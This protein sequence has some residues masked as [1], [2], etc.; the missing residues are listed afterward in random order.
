VDLRAKLARLKPI[1][2]REQPAPPEVEEPSG[3][4]VPPH[5]EAL[6]IRLAEVLEKSREKEARRAAVRAAAIEERLRRA[7]L[8]F[9]THETDLGPLHVRAVRHAGSH[10]VGRVPL[11]AGIE[12]DAEAIAL[13]ALDPTIGAVDPARALYLD[14]EATGLAGGTGTIPFLIGLA[15]FEE[16]EL[17]VE[18]LL[19]RRLGDEAPILARVAERIA[20]ASMLVSFNGK[21]FDL[22]L[23]RT[24]FVMNR[25]PRPA[26][27]PHL[28]LVHL[29][30]RVHRGV[31]GRGGDGD[32]RSGPTIERW[33]GESE[34][35][36]LRRRTSCKLVALE[37]QVLG[38]VRVDD[39]PSAEVPARY[40]HFLRTGD[41]DAIRAVCDHNLWDVV[42]MAALIG[43][44]SQ[45]VRR[46]DGLSTGGPTGDGSGDGCEDDDALDGRDLVGIAKTLERAG[47]R[48][49]AR[50]AAD[51]AVAQA[52]GDPDLA[53]A[54]RRTRGVIA[55]RSRD[56]ARALEDF[57]HLAGTHDDPIARLELAKLYEHQIRDPRTALAFA[58]SG[59]SEDDAAAHR[60]LTRLE[61]KVARAEQ[62]SLVPPAIASSPS[63]RRET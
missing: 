35:E 57:A 8:P 32:P 61:R 50:R 37:R 10:R 26:E 39:V 60:R 21:A 9:D 3:S 49:R 18:Q 56:T 41:A 29:A 47:A 25:V 38:F 45:A 22:P 59:T 51:R 7:P 1:G 55:K 34:A 28:D 16:G 12:V 63:K 58:T 27:P 52:D 30:R 43:V 44:Y 6:R 24:R 31:R 40:G 36:E 15:W 2:A 23:L 17:V 13:L 48:D 4:S 54:A 11:R 33:T 42:S 20:G 14:T 62:L 19:L 5:I 46:L 53:V